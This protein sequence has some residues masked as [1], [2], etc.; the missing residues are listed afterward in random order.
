MCYSVT[1]KVNHSQKA[2]IMWAEVSCIKAALRKFL[3]SLSVKTDMSCL[4]RFNL[5]A[6]IHTV[7][8]TSVRFLVLLK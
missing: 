2:N 7:V 4:L 1:G 5:L 8:V 3:T 6:V